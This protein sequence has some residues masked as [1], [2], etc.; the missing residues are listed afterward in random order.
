MKHLKIGLLLLYLA[1]ATTLQAAIKDTLAVH[2]VETSAGKTWQVEIALE[3]RLNNNLTAFQMDLHLPE[4]F[5]FDEQS[6]TTAT[7]LLGH[8]TAL[9]FQKERQLRVL[10]YSPTNVAIPGNTGTLF[11]FALHK[12]PNVPQGDYALTIDS[13]FFSKRDGTELILPEVHT[14]LGYH[15]FH[16]VVYR[17]DGAEFLR[18]PVGEGLPIPPVTPPE[19]EGHH[20]VEW[21]GLPTRMPTHD[22]TVDAVY[23]V[24]TY[25]ITYY[26]DEVEYG[27]QTVKYGEKI[28][29]LTVSDTDEKHFLGW[30]NLP[31][32]MPAHDLDIYGRTEATGIDTIEADTRVTVYNLQGHCLHTGADWHKVRFLLRPGCYIINGK[33]VYWSSPKK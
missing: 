2:L 9:A 29:P 21:T 28:V 27:K 25:S 32:T 31:E 20:F 6:W 30:E 13:V 3:N 10:A 16:D 23:A 15:I 19:K 4:G 17:V 11:R 26:L 12:R 1:L 33:L 8:T 18:Q 5:D 7:R 14:T 22:L 24:N